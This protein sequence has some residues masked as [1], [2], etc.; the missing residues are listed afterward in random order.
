VR[1]LDLR[2]EGY[3]RLDGENFTLIP[4]LSGHFRFIFGDI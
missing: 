3:Y 1:L 2:E 4:G